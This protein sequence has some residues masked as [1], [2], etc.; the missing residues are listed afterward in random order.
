MSRIKKTW[1]RIEKTSAPPVK[2]VIFKK[3]GSNKY[4]CPFT[5][6]KKNKP[7]CR[8]FHA[9]AR[10]A[11]MVEHHYD[12]L[13]EWWKQKNLG[14]IVFWTNYCSASLRNSLLMQLDACMRGCI[15]VLLHYSTWRMKADMEQKVA[16]LF[17][18]VYDGVLNDP[19]FPLPKD[20]VCVFCLDE[21]KHPTVQFC[22]K[23]PSHALHPACALMQLDIWLVEV[24]IYQLWYDKDGS[25][26]YTDTFNMDHEKIRPPSALLPPKCAC[27]SCR[28]PIADT[29]KTLAKFRLAIWV[30]YHGQLKEYDT[31]FPYRALEER[32]RL[33]AERLQETLRQETQ[34]LLE[35]LFDPEAQ[36]INVEDSSDS[37]YIPTPGIDNHADD[38]HDN[39]SGS[40]VSDSLV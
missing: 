28:E 36:P 7:H 24:G 17:P 34:Q 12:L 29:W 21:D 4:Q 5:V 10:D 32:E 20:S 25:A 6:G 23:N 1:A 27:M 19:R 39:S 11:H 37:D 33:T 26:L 31:S 15:P 40:S 9:N 2:P 16:A 18:P 3:G 13:L 35:E 22:R 30:E 8:E 38:Y 14:R